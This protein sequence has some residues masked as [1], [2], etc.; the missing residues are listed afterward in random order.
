M[1]GIIAAMDIELEGLRPYIENPETRLIAGREFVSGTAFG[2][3]VVLAVCGIGKVNAAV[4][5]QA[6]IMAYKPDRIINTGVAGSLS[7]ELSICDTV[8]AEYA[9]QHDMDTTALGDAPGFVSTV[10][11][12]RFPVCEKLSAELAEAMNSVGANVRRGGIATG[13]RFVCK[14]KD[15]EDI[16]KAFDCIACEMEG[17]AIAHVCYL[18]SVP[19]AIIRSISDGADEEADMSYTEFASRAAD[20]SVKGLL[21]FLKR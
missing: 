14:K 6:M 1:T 16:A 13:D 11:L 19:C 21:S 20:T 18:N 12:I 2:H 5:A 7:S 4:C 17:G 9:V 3:K 8:I 15:K 10:N